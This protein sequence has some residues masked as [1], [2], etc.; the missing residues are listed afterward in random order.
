MDGLLTSQQGASF[1][2]TGRLFQSL[3]F[4]IKLAMVVHARDS[5]TGEI[6]VEGSEIQIILNY[7]A[8]IYEKRG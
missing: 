3:G 4:L 7:R 2:F 1:H 6:E 5:S 8:T